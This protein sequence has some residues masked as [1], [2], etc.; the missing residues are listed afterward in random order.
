MKKRT[1]YKSAPKRVGDAIKSAVVLD[2]I[3]PP[4]SELAQK[5]KTQKVTINLSEKSLSFFKHEAKKNHVPYQQMI[6]ELLDKY[7]DHF[8]KVK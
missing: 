8:E 1:K 7:T 5:E 2:D 3:L 6:K 4:P